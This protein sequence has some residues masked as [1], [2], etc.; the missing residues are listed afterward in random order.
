MMPTR[1]VVLG[2]MTK[3]PVGGVVWQTLHYLE[4]LRRLGCEVH[5]VEAHARTP[6]M[7]L[8]T[9]TDDGSGRAADFLQRTL[10][11]IGMRDRWALWALHDDGAV[12]GTSRPEL[13][14]WLQRADAVINL[15]GGTDPALVE[16]A[17]GRLVYLE[18]DPVQ[19]QIELHD[20]VA[21]TREFLDAHEAFFT[22]G[23]L[24]GRPSCRLPT[25]REYTFHPTR[26]PVI[27][28]WWTAPPPAVG[29]AYTTVANWRQPWREVVFGGERYGWSKDQEF[30]M[31]LDL[32]TRLE[33]AVDFEL[34]LSGIDEDGRRRLE[35]H[36]W[37]TADGLRISA[38]PDDYRAYIASSA[39]EFTVAKD[40]NVRLRS[41]WFSDRSATYLAAG[42]AVVTQSTGFEEVLPTGD[43]LWAF[44]DA[45]EAAEAISTIAADPVRAGAAARNL[46]LEYFAHDRVLTPLLETVGLRPWRG[47]RVGRLADPEL[48]LG[49]RSRRPLR[50]A[51]GVEERALGHP[52]PAALPTLRSPAPS[53]S[54]VI[55]TWNHLALTRLCLD[56]LL[57]D[58]SLRD[59]EIIVVDNG[60]EDGTPD[61]LG[62]F[63]R[64]HPS[65]S[66]VSNPTN[67][68][69]AAA[70]NQGVRQATAARVVLL[71]NDTVV[72]PGSIVRLVAHLDDPTI[73]VIGALAPH[74]GNEARIQVDYDTFGGHV[75]L[76]ERLAVT[77]RGRNQT[78]AMVTLFCAALRRDVMAEVGPLDETFGLGMFE[79]DDYAVR[80]RRAGYRCALALDV[81]VHHFGEGSFGDLFASGEH[82]RVFRSNRERFERKWEASWEPHRRS[83]GSEYVALADRLVRLVE[84]TTPPG[85]VVA[86]ISHGDPTLCEFTDRG[87]RHFPALANGEFAGH[88]PS[89]DDE[90][91]TQLDRAL[92]AGATHFVVP[93]TSRWWLTHYRGFAE[94]IHLEFEPVADIDGTGMVFAAAV[95]P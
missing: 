8:T 68:G 77:Q 30:D 21:E 95:T 66:V 40:Q 79:D 94:R 38:D 62:A 31:V 39:A 10:D 83:N 60:S 29:A 12:Y 56:S 1:I 34:A 51:P 25:S 28:D 13:D 3:I 74:A 92:A 17:A 49:V 14:R 70:S 75:A 67:L 84:A 57:A 58:P 89:D 90:A 35:Q 55:V 63:A 61:V 52:V 4:G 6:S 9:E 36:G 46:A 45:D 73:G 87:G 64:R 42:R 48:P 93:H 65:I 82:S 5:Y 72:A 41:G 20:G 33:G 19:L 2:M 32:P 47:R 78:T 50:L 24:W 23:E 26:Q 80:L 15:H 44:H 76:A 27:C 86:V 85:S 11:R 88:H 54:I 91:G 71:N 16:A 7:F 69:F 37:R 81:V 59:A 22:Y 18:T 53:V 43:G